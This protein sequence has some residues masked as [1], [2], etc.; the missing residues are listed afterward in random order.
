MWARQTKIHSR[1]MIT[2][3]NITGRRDSCVFLQRQRTPTLDN[4]LEDVELKD[5]TERRESLR[6][7]DKKSK[8]RVEQDQ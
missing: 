2:R 6:D 3:T 7:T 8:G 5:A 4:K 1:R